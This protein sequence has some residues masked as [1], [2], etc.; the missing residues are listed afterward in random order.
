MDKLEKIGIELFPYQKEVL[1]HVTNGEKT[2]FPYPPGNGRYYFQS[3]LYLMSIL[4]RPENC[5]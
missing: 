4:L 5:R 2:Y 1:K 3:L